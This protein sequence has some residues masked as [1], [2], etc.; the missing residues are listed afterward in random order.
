VSNGAY[1]YK[2]QRRYIIDEFTNQS[3]YGYVYAG[4]SLPL[5]GF[6]GTALLVIDER[7]FN[8]AFHSQADISLIT[9]DISLYEQDLVG[10][11]WS[12]IEAHESGY[13]RGVEG[14]ID[15]STTPNTALQASTIK[16]L[17]QNGESCW[18]NRVTF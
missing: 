15:S 8:S 12:V 6:R 16:K 13:S 5:V 17:S 9:D 3:D 1:E 7:L 14:D 2:V 11:G 18:Y 4:R 10:D